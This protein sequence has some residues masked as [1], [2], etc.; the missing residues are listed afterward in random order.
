MERLC[1]FD[2]ET[3]GLSAAQGHRAIEIGIVEI[4]NRK[5]TNRTFH[6]YLNPDRSIDQRAQEV[7]GISSSF[8]ADKPRFK[9]IAPDLIEFVEN[10]TMI[11]HNASFDESF[12][13]MELERIGL[14]PLKNYCIE[15]TDSLLIARKLYPGKKNSLDAL[16]KRL[17]ISNSHRDLH[18]ALLDAELLAQVYLKMTGGQEALS[19]EHQTESQ[20]LKKSIKK[21]NVKIGAVSEYE[22][23]QHEKWIDDLLGSTTVCLFK[24]IQK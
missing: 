19:F 3:T 10:S 15:I 5:I 24:D 12:L 8:L 20:I 7:H 23:Q 1:I 11:A 18:G 16:C 2:L 22:L 21:F 17:D 14:L 4:I 13:T 9:D 6:V